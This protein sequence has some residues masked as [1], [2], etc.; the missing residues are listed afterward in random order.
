MKNKT[1]IARERANTVLKSLDQSS[2]QRS[3]C[4]NES[5]VKNVTP[6]YIPQ[7]Q[8]YAIHLID[9]V[10]FPNQNNELA[11][12]A[13]SIE[14]L[15]DSVDWFKNEHHLHSCDVLKILLNFFC[16]SSW[17]GGVCEAELDE[18]EMQKYDEFITKLQEVDPD[19]SNTFNGW[20]DLALKVLNH[21]YLLWD[22]TWAYD[23]L[24]YMLRKEHAKEYINP[25]YAC[26]IVKDLE[27][28]YL[29][30]HAHLN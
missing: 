23:A 26:L 10:G 14:M 6:V 19:I 12:Q 27:K 29:L 1:N 16:C 15:L 28:Q 7:L 22:C 5:I 18:A 4:I 11:I 24:I 17:S 30:E 8:V 9:R 20:G 2:N 3:N 21:W 25:I 13:A